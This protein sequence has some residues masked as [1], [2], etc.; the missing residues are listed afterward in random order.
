MVSEVKT[1]SI[2]IITY[3]HEK[4]IRDCLNSVLAQKVDANIEILVGDD[5]STDRTPKILLDYYNKY[6]DY[7]K[8]ILR[9]RNI[10]A[11]ANIVDLL[12][13]AKGD[14]IAF[15]EGDDFWISRS[16]LSRQLKFLQ[17]SSDIGVVH[18]VLLV[19]KD[20]VKLRIQKLNWVMKKNFYCLNNYELYKLPEHISSLMFKNLTNLSYLNLDM[21]LCSRHTFDKM[22]Y[23]IVLSQGTI[24][25]IGKT[26]SA[27][28]V[29]RSCLTNSIVGRM[30]R[31][32]K[33]NVF[34]EMIIFLTM[35][36]W[37]YCQF[38]VRKKFI[39][40]KSR[41]IV[42]A[43]FHKVKGYD[44]SLLKLLKLCNHRLLVVL[45]L[46]VSFV[47]QSVDKFSTILKYSIR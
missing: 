4:F 26:M 8:L 38:G 37:L 1:I 6:P 41:L 47:R 32:H 42:T 44:I 29:M 39:S 2:L 43:L 12:T 17:E 11:S 14:Y 46:P 20:K 15:C 9:K 19:D 33:T 10:G 5:A 35:E 7:I 31:L 36:K 13:K 22:I 16:K 18:N 28:R 34:S 24:G 45:Y 3:N 21:L 27:Y 40:A 30:N 23:L 25:R